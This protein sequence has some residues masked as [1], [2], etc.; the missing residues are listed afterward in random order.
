M[1][2]NIGIDGNE[3]QRVIFDRLLPSLEG[4]SF[5]LQ[6][7]ALMTLCVLMAKQDITFDELQEAVMNLSEYLILLVADE[8]DK[9]KVN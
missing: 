6:M 3:V 8:P 1:I 2:E 9:T 7:T 5:E 4:E